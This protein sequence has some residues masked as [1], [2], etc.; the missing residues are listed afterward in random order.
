MAT[1]QLYFSIYNQALN[2][3]WNKRLTSTLQATTGVK[4]VS[5]TRQNE[6][7][8]AQ[9]N[10][11]YDYLTNALDDI[12]KVILKSGVAVI[13]INIHFPSVITGVSDPYGASILSLTADEEIGQI[14]GVLG[15][16]VSSSG[17]LKAE[18]AP[19]AENK[20][21]VIQKIIQHIMIRKGNN[22]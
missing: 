16:A 3:E 14:E 18:I 1:I 15:V 19:A 12:E 9:V 20:N 21:K 10:V 22:P 11:D 6:S 7:S 13:T 4:E 17:I 2:N 5:I 8:E